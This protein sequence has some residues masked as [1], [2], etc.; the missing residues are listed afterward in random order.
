M[1][2]D[3]LSFPRAVRKAAMS[4]IGKMSSAWSGESKEKEKESEGPSM[5][6]PS[7]AVPPETAMAPRE[8]PRSAA[9]PSAIA[10]GGERW[11]WLE[12]IAE[13]KTGA[14][15][16]EGKP[17]IAGAS[18][19][20]GY[21][22]IPVEGLI[23]GIVRLMSDGLGAVVKTGETA[24]SFVAAEVRTE[25]KGIAAETAAEFKMLRRYIGRLVCGR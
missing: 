4:V 18:A 11:R 7:A 19:G 24:S 8:A 2:V 16:K 9:A 6:V 13:A 21:D 14:A 20:I 22:E 25:L 3:V 10:G 1:G 17:G 23:A 5:I 12:R 15:A